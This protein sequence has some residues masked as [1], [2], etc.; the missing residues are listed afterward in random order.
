MYNE[1]SWESVLK[2]NFTAFS[3]KNLKWLKYYNNSWNL[4]LNAVIWGLLF[5]LYVWHLA[6]TENDFK[7]NNELL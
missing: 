2:E 7:E 4:L 1:N 6:N 5:I 3:F